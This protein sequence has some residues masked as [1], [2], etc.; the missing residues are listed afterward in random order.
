VAVVFEA[1]EPVRFVRGSV[2]FRVGDGP[3]CADINGVRYWRVRAQGDDG[4]AGTFDLR[5]TDDGWVIH[6]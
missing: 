2:R 5:E 3:K 1:A 4:T 6:E